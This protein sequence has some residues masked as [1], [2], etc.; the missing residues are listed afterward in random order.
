[1]VYY[2]D[3]I[4]D[5]ETEIS[6]LRS[7]RSSDKLKKINEN[8]DNEALD[9]E[10]EMAPDDI[11]TETL[12]VKGK[13]MGERVY[14]AVCNEKEDLDEIILT[15]TK[16][17]K[18]IQVVMEEKLEPPPPAKTVS[19]GIQV[20]DLTSSSLEALDSSQSPAPPAPPPPPA[21]DQHPPPPPPPPP[22]V[23]G[24]FQTIHFVVRI[25]KIFSKHLQTL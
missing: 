6:R 16:L 9:D 3:K 15:R 22:S 17:D 11:S 23:N 14:A 4:Q 21:S 1:M 5:L 25:S 24:E 20:G 19:K 10:E 7:L 2:V 13:K 12:A 8:S 18:G